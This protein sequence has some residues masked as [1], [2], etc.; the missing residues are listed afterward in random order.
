MFYSKQINQRAFD[1][2]PQLRKVRQYVRDH[3][4]EYLPLRKAAQIA[5]MERKY[6]S[7]FFHQK[8]GICFSD[9]LMEL[10]I[11]K[12]VSLIEAE[13]HSIAQIAFEIGYMDLRTFQRAFKRCMGLT[14]I[15]FKKKVRMFKAYGD[16]DH[17]I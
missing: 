17:D 10:R 7:T 2:Y 6:F 16:K 4:S 8:V 1:Y 11:R 9:W 15:E 12:A 3:Y 5:G 14:P 13:N